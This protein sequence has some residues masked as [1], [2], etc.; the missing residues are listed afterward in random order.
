MI[1][2]DKITTHVEGN[3]NTILS[4]MSSLMHHVC[5]DVEEEVGTPYETVIEQ[6]L[7]AMQ[8]Y[9]LVDSGMTPEEAID[10]LDMK[11]NIRRMEVTEEDGTKYV[12]EGTCDDSK[13]A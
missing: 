13:R 12:V 3:I 4:E 1:K 10:V 5:K 8:V 7:Q 9:K 11:G 2:Q 6:V